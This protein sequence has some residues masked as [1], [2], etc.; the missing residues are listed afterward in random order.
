MS[1][2]LMAFIR[3]NTDYTKELFAPIVDRLGYEYDQDE[4]DDIHELRTTAISE[5]ADA[6]D[7]G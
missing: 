3:S 7:E 2:L 6:G 4:S 5:A 1:I